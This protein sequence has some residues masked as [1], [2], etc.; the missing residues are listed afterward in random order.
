MI[1]NNQEQ[2]RTIKNKQEQIRTINRFS[3]NLNESFNNKEDFE[4]QLKKYLSD[5]QKK[6]PELKSERELKQKEKDDI[7]ELNKQVFLDIYQKNLNIQ[8]IVSNLFVKKIE[9]DED[10]YSVAEVF[11]FT[12]KF[13]IKSGK[14]IKDWENQL[15]E[16][17]KIKAKEYTEKIKNLEKTINDYIKEKNFYDAKK[18]LDLDSV[19]VSKIEKKN[20][21]GIEEAIGEAIENERFSLAESALELA[22]KLNIDVK[23]SEE[24]KEKIKSKITGFL[25]QGIWR[26]FWDV[27]ICCNIIN[28]FELKEARGLIIKVVNHITEQGVLSDAKELIEENGLN[29]NDFQKIKGWE[30]A[31]K[32]ALKNKELNNFC[33]GIEIANTFNTIIKF[34]K[35]KLIDVIN[36]Y[37]KKGY[38]DSIQKAIE[39]AKKINI[40]ITSEDIKNFSD[41][42]ERLVFDGRFGMVDGAILLAEKFEIEIK[43][44]EEKEKYIQDINQAI[45][46]KD[47]YR[48]YQIFKFAEKNNVQI[49]KKQIEKITIEDIRELIIDDKIDFVNVGL[50]FSKLVFGTD[51]LAFEKIVKE[52]DKSKMTK[53]LFNENCWEI[54]QT[55]DLNLLK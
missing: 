26:D 25:K 36:Y 8:D 4:K 46:K 31:T 39:L 21:K 2:S 37:I 40:E 34:Q 5:L 44:K 12:K 43:P 3:K 24:Q 16:I 9:N 42:V 23:I 50:E 10:F 49:D 27:K 22:E 30:E 14:E 53:I 11:S 38:F 13:Q 45:E 6:Y 33:A 54:L 48:A 15:L 51:L 52:D 28:K 18:I 29:S 55:G 7:L 17:I 41:V 47:F 1:K 32:E 35:E 19:D 20:I